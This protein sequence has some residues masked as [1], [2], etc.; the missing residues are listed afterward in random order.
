MGGVKEDCLTLNNYNKKLA[1][2]EKKLDDKVKNMG[3]V[4][5]RDLHL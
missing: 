1:E 3:P 4:S 2:S 5:G